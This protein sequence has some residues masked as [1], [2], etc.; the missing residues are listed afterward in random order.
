MDLNIARYCLSQW[1]LDDSTAN[2]PAFTF[3]RKT[4]KNDTWTYQEV[5]HLIQ[6]IGKGFL[7][8]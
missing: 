1:A 3:A 4:Q 5:G 6:S 8:L 2:Q 7:E